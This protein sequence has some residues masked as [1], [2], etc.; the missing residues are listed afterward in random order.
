MVDRLTSM[1]AF[2]AA[3]ESGSYA[4]AA[5]RLGLSPQMVAKHVAALEQRLG[6]RLLNRTTRR[7][8]LTELGSAYLERCKHILGE[9]QAA[10]SLAQIMNA[11]PRGKLRISAPVTFGSYSLMPFVTGFLR[12][13]PEVEIDLHLTDRYIDLVEE[14]YEAAFRIG[15]LADSSLTARPL[16]PYRL[17]ACAAPA[18]LAA[19][20]TP[21]VPAD[22]EQHE[23]LGYA[24]WSRPADNQWQF[25]R[26]GRVHEVQ[27]RSRLQVN[28]SKALL[29]AAVDGFGIVLGPADFLEPAR[30]A[31]ELVQLLPGY[32]A[33]SRAM[34][35]LY[36]P[37][38]QMTAKL[39]HFVDAAIARFG[40]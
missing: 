3:A 32:E 12:E 31:G 21:R 9:A 25:R 8:N 1:E 30:A 20:G 35:L 13:H 38:R 24:Y 5:T 40:A 34:H 27:V 7:Q 4:R 15:P 10:D 28:E 33:P 37:D 2:V 19:R 16:A 6:A 14:G 23:C 11:T 39:R 18:Y 26:D 29:S 22:L 36:R 17:I